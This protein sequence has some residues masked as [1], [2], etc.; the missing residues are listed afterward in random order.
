MSKTLKTVLAASV[1]ASAF[2]APAALAEVTGNIGVTS[3]YIWRGVT[4]T[5]DGPA[6]SGGIDYAHASGL[7]AGTWASNA[8]WTVPVSYEL[9]AYVGYAGEMG[10]IGYDVGYIAYMYPNASAN[11]FNELYVGASFGD[12]SAMVSLDTENSNTYV[13]AGYDFALPGDWGVGLHVGSYTLDAGTDYTD[14]AVTFSKDDFSFALSD[15]SENAANG[16]SDNYRV[17]A[18][19]SKSF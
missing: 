3:N 9:D 12:L 7:Y 4:Q 16:Q 8:S 1:L 19:W 10:A 6:I 18:S 14:Y 11:D 15:T 2:A 17:A 5:N 13:E